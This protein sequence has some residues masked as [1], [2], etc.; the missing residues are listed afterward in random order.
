MAEND[1]KP[2]AAVEQKS[3][4]DNE[5]RVEDLDAI[6]GDPKIVASPTEFV[7]RPYDPRPMEDAARR[8]IAYLLISL[9]IGICAVSFLAVLRCSI[10]VEDVIK[11][12]Q[13]ILG[14]VVALVSAATGFYY[15]TKMHNSNS[16][17]NK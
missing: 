9:L 15:G 11:L 6:G 16:D 2:A 4:P 3:A 7:A 8:R 10:P 5:Q 12:L 14:P 17:S 1:P 13:V